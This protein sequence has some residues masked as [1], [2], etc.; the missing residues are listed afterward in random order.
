MIAQ[1]EVSA[2]FPTKFLS[3]NKAEGRHIRIV[4]LP[5][6]E[7][8]ARW[9]AGELERMHGA[10]RRW[11]DLAVLYRQHAHRDKL[12]EELSRRKIPFVITRLSIL[13]HP[14]VRDVLA[15]L[16]LIAK[17]YDDVACARILA[18]PAWQMQPE[19]LLRLAERAKRERAADATTF[20]NLRKASWR[21]IPR[22]AAPMNCW[23]FC[24]RSGKRCGAA[25]HGKFWRN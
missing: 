15:Y 18:M 24:W 17:P 23:R 11:A 6:K 7:S 1:N 4:E 2:D 13:V 10:G 20:C 22:T 5:D 3:P 21:L 9:V 19:D 8:E 12:V 16:R 14:L 25:P